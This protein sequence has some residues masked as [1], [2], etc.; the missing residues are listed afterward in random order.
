MPK[1]PLAAP[2]RGVRVV[3]PFIIG[4]SVWG[5]P[6]VYPAADTERAQTYRSPTPSGFVIGLHCYKTDWFARYGG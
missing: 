1:E 5:G 2:S 3:N 4:K 6:D